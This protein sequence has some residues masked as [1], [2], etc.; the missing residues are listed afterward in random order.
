MAK[1]NG[2]TIL[3]SSV[4]IIDDYDASSSEDNI[5]WQ[6]LDR[7]RKCVKEGEDKLG[8]TCKDYTILFV[9][10]DR[11]SDGI[12]LFVNILSNKS[13]IIVLSMPYLDKEY[14]KFISDEIKDKIKYLGDDK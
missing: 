5:G 2:E 9:P 13:I 10:S 7:V 4:E 12:L 6:V 11:K 14:L 8:F 1:Y 3:H